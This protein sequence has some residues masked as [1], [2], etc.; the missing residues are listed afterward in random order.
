[1]TKFLAWHE[2][3]FILAAAENFINSSVLKKQCCLAC[4]DKLQSAR[5]GWEN[6]CMGEGIIAR[7]D[8]ANKDKKQGI[9]TIQDI[10]F[11]WAC[12]SSGTNSAT[13]YHLFLY[14]HDRHC[15]TPFPPHQQNLLRLHAHPHGGGAA[16]FKL[17][18]MVRLIQK[19]PRILIICWYNKHDYLLTLS[20]DHC[21][22]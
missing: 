17:S 4:L 15:S 18:Y 13:E 22:Y 19:S 16:C 14:V 1:M 20:T 7:D 8:E 11:S 10:L 12:K 5:Q 3:K 2:L 9:G 21:H 6:E